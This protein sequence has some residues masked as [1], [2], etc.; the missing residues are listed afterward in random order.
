MTPD[1]NFLLQLLL[2]LGLI[3][4]VAGH[5]LTLIRAGKSQ[6]REVS[7]VQDAVSKE[8]LERLRLQNLE[9]HRIIHE[10]ITNAKKRADEQQAV[11]QQTVLQEVGKV[12]DRVNVVLAAVSRLEG[13][14]RRE[15][16]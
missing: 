9:D 3:G 12:H 6:R 15:K 2:T 11:M 8:E 7:M 5:I 10:R 13:T 14:M 1:A 4:S 16:E